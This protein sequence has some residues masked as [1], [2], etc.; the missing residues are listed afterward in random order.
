AGSALVG[1]IMKPSSP[2][3]ADRALMPASMALNHGMPPI[4]TT[5]PSLTSFA[6]AGTI[7]AN[8]SAAAKASIVPVFLCIV[9]PPMMQAI[10]EFLLCRHQRHCPS[11]CDLVH[12][13]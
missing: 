12:F 13:E 4:L 7:A 8:D 1:P 3:S 11:A 9:D 10:E 5:T 2:K 6:T